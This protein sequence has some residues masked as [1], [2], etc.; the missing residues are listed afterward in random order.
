MANNLI[1]R[2][3]FG[4]LARFDPFT[5][6]DEIFRDF[7][8]TPGLQRSGRDAASRIRVDITETDQAYQIKAEIPGVSKDDIKVSV[9]GNRVSINAELK[10][11]RQTDEGGRM[12]RSER[13]YGQQYRSFTLPQEV[14]DT[15]AQARYQDGVLELSLPKKAGAGAKQL[16]IQ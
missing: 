16:S 1:P 10:E 4:G 11:E 5:D 8:G 6:I 12:V 9:E 7:F 2:D 14:D 15:S 13:M 3:P